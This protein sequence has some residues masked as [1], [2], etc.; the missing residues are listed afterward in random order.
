MGHV[1]YFSDKKSE[2]AKDLHLVK[3]LAA[4]LRAKSPRLGRCLSSSKALH[5]ECL[6]EFASSIPALCRKRGGM[7]LYLVSA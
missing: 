5:C 4:L 2:R 6:K 1:Y 7:G 3:K